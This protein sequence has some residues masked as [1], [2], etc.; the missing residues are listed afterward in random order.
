MSNSGTRAGATLV[1]VGDPTLDRL[2]A[3]TGPAGSSNTALAAAVTGLAAAPPGSA[4]VLLVE[5]ISDQAALAALAARQG[6]DLRHEGVFVVP[7]GGATNIAAFASLLGP[8][9]LG[10]RLA[11]LCDEGEEPDFRRGLAHAGL[12]PGPGRAGLER[13]G[14]YVCVADLED[15][16]IRALGAA[17]V[18]QLIAAEGELTRFRTFTR[19]PAHRGRPAEQQLHRFMGTKSGRKAR[20]GRVL[21]AALPAARIPRP[22]RLVLAHP[23]TTPDSTG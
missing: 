2:I 10:A 15:E 5:G 21:A 1:Q 13:L 4:T 12:A 22:L 17:A 6:R 3:A 14:F 23:A 16:M 19:Q 20:Y 9:G 8:R 11:G 18:E 7:M